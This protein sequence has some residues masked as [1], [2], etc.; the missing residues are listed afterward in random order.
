MSPLSLSRNS[1]VSQ[2]MSM[3]WERGPFIVTVSAVA[4]VT[5]SAGSR[6]LVQQE[7]DE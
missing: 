7:C 4:G 6:D 1:L 5:Q 3:K 2:L